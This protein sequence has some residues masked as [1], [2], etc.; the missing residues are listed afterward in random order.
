MF[1]VLLTN[2]ICIFFF[3]FLYFC[4]E[5]RKISCGHPSMLDSKDSGFVI[6]TGP[7]DPYLLIQV[8]VSQTFVYGQQTP[9]CTG[10]SKSSSKI[11]FTKVLLICKKVMIQANL[12]IK[13]RRVSSSWD[14]PCQNLK[15][16]MQLVK[17]QI[18]LHICVVW[19]FFA[20][21]VH[22]T[23]SLLSKEGRTRTIAILVWCTGWS[24][25]LYGMMGVNGFK[26]VLQIRAIF[27]YFFLVRHENML[28]ILVSSI[29]VK[30]P[31]GMLSYVNT[32]LLKTTPY[33]E[34]CKKLLHQN[35]SWLCPFKL[36]WQADSKKKK[37]KKKKKNIYKICF[38]AKITNIVF[39]IHPSHCFR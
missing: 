35:I 10:S 20:D 26:K 14:S 8:M 9:W 24:T 16:D 25:L 1:W 29:P 15:Y 2:L 37:K 6:C 27:R 4:G 30:Y 34:L 38:S 32:F 33:L 17:I 5:I 12:Y 31:Q 21:H 19:S 3:F 28:W 18:S 39:W 23:A 7:R 36:S 11:P 22:C 13:D